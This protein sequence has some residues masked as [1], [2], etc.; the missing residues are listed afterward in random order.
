MS[1]YGTP[2]TKDRKAAHRK[3]CGLLRENERWHIHS[4]VPRSASVEPSRRTKSSEFSPFDRTCCHR[5]FICIALK[6]TNWAS[7]E[8]HLGA[9]GTG[10]AEPPS[11][12]RIARKPCNRELA[13][14]G[15]VL[16]SPAAGG[17][18]HHESVGKAVRQ[19]R[20]RRRPAGRTGPSCASPSGSGA[21]QQKGPAEGA[22]PFRSLQQAQE[23]APSAFRRSQ[24]KGARKTI[25]ESSGR[26][27]ALVRE[28]RYAGFGCLNNSSRLEKFRVRTGTAPGTAKLCHGASRDP[29]QPFAA[30]AVIRVGH[31]SR[32]LK[33]PSIRARKAAS[34]EGMGVIMGSQSPAA[35]RQPSSHFLCTSERLATL[36][37]PARPIW[38]G[39]R[40]ASGR[41]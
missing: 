32:F 11:R 18:E 27:S 40:L 38:S 41:R 2:S 36:G 6:L 26:S 33:Q 25:L 12:R 1:S 8:R 24:P 30:V 14:T 35:A 13:R 31:A 10:F 29:R 37:S 23:K 19:A 20:A 21:S 9:L 3:G 7:L 4:H 15:V 22:R 34:V 28:L 17:G 16:A 39:R 5:F